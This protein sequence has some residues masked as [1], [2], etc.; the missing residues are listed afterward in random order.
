MSWG[1][2]I[3]GVAGAVAGLFGAKSANRANRRAAR[4]QMQFQERMSSTAHQREVEDLRAA[5]LNPI[6]SATRGAST[7][8]GA[9]PHAAINTGKAAAEGAQAAAL[10]AA[11]L[12]NLKANTAKLQQDTKTS[13]ANEANMWGLKVKIQNEIFNLQDQRKI[14]NATAKGIEY[15][16]INKKIDT[17]FWQSAEGLK[18]MKNLG[19]NPLMLKQI[20]SK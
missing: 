12:K 20:L 10:A 8:S 7:P 9:L 5:G 6:L 13:A 1:A 4:E 16:N 2:A 11:N 17:D 15:D 18:A 19:L 14:I 3:G